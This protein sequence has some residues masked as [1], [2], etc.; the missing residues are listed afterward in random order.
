LQPQR[1][2]RPKRHARD[3]AAAVASDP[4]WEL[5][6]EPYEVQEGFIEIRS[7]E[8]GGRVVTVVEVL[9]PSNKRAGSDGRKAYRA[10]Q[11]EVLCSP[12]HLLELDL[13][14]QGEHT[15]A[16]PPPERLL[17]HGP[18]DYL[19]CLSRANERDHCQVWGFTVRQRLPRILVP[20][21]EEDEDLRLDLQAVFDR[22]YD[23]GGYATAMNYG[24][25]PAIPLG[26][27]DAEWADA[28]LREKGLRK[29]RRKPR[30][31]NGN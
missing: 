6:R 7:A 21:A 14:R 18:Y 13:L 4:P 16:A 31:R 27:A 25:E 24:A 20:L 3:G 28:L 26:R 17:R 23:D 2:R 8:E 29:K 1:T 30:S 12:T 10:K 5:S 22:V 9:S 19:V 15:V 11:R